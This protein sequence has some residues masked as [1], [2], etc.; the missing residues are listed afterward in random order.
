MFRLR[1]RLLRGFTL[2]E[3]VIAI[4]LLAIL[5]AA[6]VIAF[7]SIHTKAQIANAKATLKSVRSAILIQRANNE[8]NNITSDGCHQRQNSW[9]TYEEVRR[10]SYNAEVDN[11]I[12]SSRMPPNLLMG[13]PPANLVAPRSPP[14]TNSFVANTDCGSNPGQIIYSLP[15]TLGANPSNNLVVAT[16]DPKGSL[17]VADPC[18]AAWAYNPYT[19]DFWASSS[20]YGSNNW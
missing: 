6:A 12:L 18:K 7:Q 3:L 8:L 16:T 14:F 11:S 2:I 15:D 10:A 9:P 20:A 5:G 1:R 4:A 17:C 19:G 13:P